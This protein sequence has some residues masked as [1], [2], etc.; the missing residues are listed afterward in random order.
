VRLRDITDLSRWISGRF[1][2]REEWREMPE[3]IELGPG[4]VVPIPR[5]LSDADEDEP[6]AGG[7]GDT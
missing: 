1:L 7:L 2:D 4:I 3:Q 6:P 5:V